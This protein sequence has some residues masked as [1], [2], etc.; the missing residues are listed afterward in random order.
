MFL[1]AFKKKRET[2]KKKFFFSYFIYLQ[3][4]DL[5]LA[6]YSNSTLTG[7]TLKW[8]KSF[9]YLIPHN[10]YLSTTQVSLSANKPKKSKYI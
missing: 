3:W 7:K 8:V 10:R 6:L 4:T 1:F 9:W 5:H 2:T